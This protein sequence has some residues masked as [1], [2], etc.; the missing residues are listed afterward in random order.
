MVARFDERAPQYD[1]DNQFF[2]EDFDELRASGYLNIAVATALGAARR[3][4]LTRFLNS[5]PTVNFADFDA[6]IWMGSRVC[7][8]IPVRA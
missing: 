2:D 6:G 1:H 8:F 4:E 7:G 5:E 3:Y